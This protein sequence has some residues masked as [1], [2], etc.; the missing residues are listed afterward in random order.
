MPTRAPKAALFA[1]FILASASPAHAGL[2]IGW[3]LLRNMPVILT[4]E[5]VR[6]EE[7]E[8]DRARR[9]AYFAT[10]SSMDGGWMRNPVFI[11]REPTLQVARDSMELEE[12]S[13]VDA[14]ALTYVRVD[15][16]NKW[17]HAGSVLAAAGTPPERD[18]ALDSTHGAKLVGTEMFL[19]RPARHYRA[20]EKTEPG[21]LIEAVYGKSVQTWAL[22]DAWFVDRDSTW[23][24]Y[25]ETAR[26]FP[27]EHS[28][29]NAD[30]MEWSPVRANEPSGF[31]LAELDSGLDPGVA[32][33]L[34]IAYEIHGTPTDPNMVGPNGPFVVVN[35]IMPL[36]STRLI[37]LEPATIPEGSFRIPEGIRVSK[38]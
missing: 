11:T 30:S 4:Q 3:Y 33:R 26:R 23:S 35:G 22:L 12:I 20:R 16:L 9:S 31:P 27:G 36:F 17:A 28:E 29:L 25:L 19:G 24:A 8:G 37:A 32:V 18:A 38:D 34:D 1:L 6:L 7:Y 15:M 2:R 14:K 21:L 10:A 5:E 13:L